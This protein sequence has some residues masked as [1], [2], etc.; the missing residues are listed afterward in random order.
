VCV[1]VCKPKE[2]QERRGQDLTSKEWNCRK[3]HKVHMT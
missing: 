1:C 3:S 2:D